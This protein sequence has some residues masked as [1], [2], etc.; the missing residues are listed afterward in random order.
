MHPLFGGGACRWPGCERVFDEFND[1]YSHLH[2]DHINGDYS[3]A[4]ARIQMEVVCQLHLQLQKERDRLQ[5]MILHLNKK[6]ELM[7]AP[8]ATSSSSSSSA[9][10][11]AALFGGQFLSQLAVNVPPAQPQPTV[12]PHH[13]HHHHHRGAPPPPVSSACPEQPAHVTTGTGTAVVSPFE[14]IAG[15]RFP[16][17][18]AADIA[19]VAVAAGAPPSLLPSTGAGPHH[20]HHPPHHQPPG[21][22]IVGGAGTAA[23]A[24]GAPGANAHQG[25]HHGS[26]TTRPQQHSPQN[27]ALG[28][29]MADANGAGNGSNGGPPAT[30][31][32]TGSKSSKASGGGGQSRPKYFSPQDSEELNY[33]DVQ[34]DVH[35]NREFYR[36]HDVRPPFTYASLIRQAIIESPEKQLTLNEI[37]NWFQ[38]TF[39]YFRRNAATWKNAIRTNLSLHKCFVRYEDDFGSFWMVDDHEFLKRRHLSRG[40]PRKYDISMPPPP[41][42]QEGSPGTSSRTVTDHATSGCPPAEPPVASLVAAAAVAAAAAAAA[43]ATSGAG[44]ESQHPPPPPQG[45]LVAD[46]ESVP[47]VPLGGLA[48]DLSPPGVRGPPSYGDEYGRLRRMP[49][50]GEAASSGAG[51]EHKAL[52]AHGGGSAAFAGRLSKRSEYSRR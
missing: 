3:A 16:A 50:A 33:P 10:A 27:A 37:Y 18:L 45:T 25:L 44:A 43:A 1:F 2:S 48:G 35:K 5:A 30:A 11:A 15:L 7:R 21:T 4:Q 8:V 26:G 32:T 49:G 52:L 13:H 19:A 23:A 40:R 24:A 42:E 41:I 39:C 17:D 28:G 20:H 29:P 46:E 6:H 31:T 51:A 36:S 14:L 12:P 38:N 34:D 47:S 22:A 9:A